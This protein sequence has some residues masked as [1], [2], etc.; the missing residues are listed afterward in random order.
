MSLDVSILVYVDP[1]IHGG[2]AAIPGG[3]LSP[4]PS[5]GGGQE[6]LPGGGTVDPFL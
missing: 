4:E 5:Y 2:Q 6:L 3:Q 1:G